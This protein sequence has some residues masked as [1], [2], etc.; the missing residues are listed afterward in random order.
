[1]V[2]T[3]VRYGILICAALLILSLY[4]A[5]GHNWYP[6]ECC[7]GAD[8]YGDCIAINPGRVA[9]HNNGDYL[10]DGKWLVLRLDVRNSPDGQYHG[11]F[12]YSGV[13]RCFFAPPS[14]S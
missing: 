9:A 3:P 7:G 1:M 14:G 11:C 6:P 8:S 5:R 12:P 10:V 13:L 4:G 2:L